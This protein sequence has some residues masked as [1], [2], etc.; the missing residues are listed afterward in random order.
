MGTIGRVHP[1]MHAMLPSSV[2]IRV[3]LDKNEVS[4]CNAHNASWRVKT[5]KKTQV[6]AASIYTRQRAF[7]VETCFCC[8]IDIMSV[9]YHNVRRQTP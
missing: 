5:N 3:M 8:G 7:G 1:I 6:H 9:I 2:V 4:Q